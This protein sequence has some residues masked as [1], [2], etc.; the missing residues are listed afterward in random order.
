[1]PPTI[2]PIRA[3]SVC[4]ATYPRAVIPSSIGASG[5][6]RPRIWKKWSMT[7][8]E[9]KP[10]SSAVRTTRASVGPIPA[11]PPGHVKLLICSPNR[12]V[13]IVAAGAQRPL[14]GAA[15]GGRASTARLID[16][17]ASAGR[18]HRFA[19][20]IGELSGKERVVRAHVEEAVAG[21]VEE[22]D[23]LLARLAGIE[24][25]VDRRPDGVRRLGG[26]DEAL[27]PRELQRRLEAA[28]LPVGP[29]AD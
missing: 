13:R 21:K 11:A 29:G 28:R 14:Q 17:P 20:A 8:I 26:R 16:R 4:A 12:M 6:P 2:K 1:M 19:V 5:G 18:G 10:T 7:Q 15:G 22:D 3:R 27:G 23:T 24:R 9:S 25:L